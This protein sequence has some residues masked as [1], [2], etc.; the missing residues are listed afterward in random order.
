MQFAGVRFNAV[1]WY[2]GTTCNEGDRRFRRPCVICGDSTRCCLGV[3]FG[4]AGK[5]DRFVIQCCRRHHNATAE[6]VAL[7]LGVRPPYVNES[8]AA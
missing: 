5:S 7:W 3:R 1:H 8:R 4:R 6:R 2:Y